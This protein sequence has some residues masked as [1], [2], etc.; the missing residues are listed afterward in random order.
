MKLGLFIIPDVSIEKEIKR[1]KKCICEE[2][3]KNNPYLSHPAHLTLFTQEVNSSKIPNLIKKIDSILYQEKSFS[4]PFTR[5]LIF[6]DD[7]LT[8]GHTLCFELKKD[9][10]LQKLQKT[11][12]QQFNGYRHASKKPN[13]KGLST[14]QISNLF[15]Y[16]FPFIGDTWIPHVTI[17]SIINCSKNDP[18]IIKF[19]NTPTP[20]ELVINNISLWEISG[21]NHK[22]LNE[23]SL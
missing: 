4:T 19:L 21:D 22:Q 2:F 8:E 23:W 1:W 3:G 14:K 17:S 11:F 10:R 13:T 18:L 7:P 6:A 15:Q 16:G 5:P 12:L 20:P 9:P